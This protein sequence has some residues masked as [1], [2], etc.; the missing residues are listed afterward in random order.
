VTSRPA[1]RKRATLRELSEITGLSPAGVSYAL[2]GQRVS[3]ATEARVRAA[4][5]R[6]GFRTDPVAR[7][8]RGGRTHMVGVVG[9]SLA[10]LW[11]Q[12]FVAGVQSALRR[13][14]LRMLLADAAGDPGDEVT[15]ARDLAD[16]RVDGLI[17]LPI[18]PAA[19]GWRDVA[20]RTPVVSVNASLHAPAGAVRFDSERGIALALDHL[21]ELGHARVAALGGGPH[22]TPRRPGLRR[23]RCGP[24]IDEARAAARRVLRASGRPTAAFTLSD[25]VACGVYA[26]CRDLGLRVPDDVSVVGFDDI[27]VAALLE[28]PLTVVGWDTQRA[29]DAAVEMLAA[30]IEGRAAGEVVIEPRLVVRE[31]TAS[32]LPARRARR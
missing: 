18:D 22:P 23:V 11:H 15:L 29:V 31:S 12:Q 24:S 6:I 10:D 28:P 13:R 2:R 5:D 30:A 26:A 21:R 1:E 19:A 16:Q 17:V 27:P 4:A 9:G 14:G 20:E 25:T 32:P 3:A 8:L 7:A